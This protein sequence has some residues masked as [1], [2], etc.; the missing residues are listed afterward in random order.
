MP[1]IRKS[2]PG[3]QRGASA[4]EFALVAPI[5]FLLLFSIVDF[6]AMMWA[7]LTMQYAVREGA[8][9]AVTGQSG[10]DAQGSRYNAVLDKIRSSSL[11]VYTMSN[12]KVATWVN[13][14]SQSSGG[15]GM[16]GSAGDI[17]VIQVTCDW[18]LLTPVVAA[19]Y[20]STGGKYRF[21]VAATMRN[22][23]F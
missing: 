2:A 19:F 1:R 23:A 16:F 15:A 20:Q 13:G 7:N 9:Y 3:R 10:L 11:G 12:A 6:G 14:T 22:E 18:P 17:V 5:F 8:R 21:S 4:V